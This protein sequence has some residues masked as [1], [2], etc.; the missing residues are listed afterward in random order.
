MTFYSANLALGSG[1]DKYARHTSREYSGNTRAP[2]QSFGT[3]RK[4]L[5]PL[6]R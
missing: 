5:R 3:R 4:G 2:G 6:S 1:T